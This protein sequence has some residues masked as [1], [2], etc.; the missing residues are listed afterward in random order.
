MRAGHFESLILYVSDLAEA[1]AFYIGW[2][3][4][5]VLFEDE[6]VVVA[7]G[8]SGRIVL[9]RNDRGHD[10]RGIFPAGS[11]VGGA[12]ALFQEEHRPQPEILISQRRAEAVLV[13]GRRHDVAEDH[14]LVSQPGDRLKLAFQVGLALGDQRRRH[15]AGRATGTGPSG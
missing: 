3:G 14:E 13:D 12:A 5:P 2:L 4:L 10:E 1:R 7:G 15:R 11:G 6:I 8:Q 9:H